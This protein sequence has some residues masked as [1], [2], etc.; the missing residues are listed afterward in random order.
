[1]QC[2]P[3]RCHP[4][5]KAQAGEELVQQVIPR[6]TEFRLPATVEAMPEPGIQDIFAALG[7]DP[8]RL[9]L[10]VGDVLN[11]VESGWCSPGA[12]SKWISL[13]RG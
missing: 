5:R 2:G 3:I 10:I 12:E 13:R 11:A 7:K 1:M 8:D 4:S 6:H 9:A